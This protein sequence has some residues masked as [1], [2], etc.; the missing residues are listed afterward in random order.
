MFQ[1]LERVGRMSVNACH[2]VN[3]KACKVALH[4]LKIGCWHWVAKNVAS[5][6]GVNG[7]KK[8]WKK[9]DTAECP[10]CGKCKTAQHM[11]ECED[12]EA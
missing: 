8:E 7:K 10:Q 1:Q 12:P 11:W 4:K 3:W 6:C 5:H 9:R 2:H